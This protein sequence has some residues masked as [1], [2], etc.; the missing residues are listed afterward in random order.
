M[1]AGFKNLEIKEHVATEIFPTLGDL[2]IRL[3][4][5]PIIPDF[6]AEKD[7]QYLEKI[8]KTCRSTK[9]IET[10]THRVTIIA[11]T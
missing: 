8:Q 4:D 2:I 6:D 11:H 3:K 1:A 9:G 7:R 5:S 10:P